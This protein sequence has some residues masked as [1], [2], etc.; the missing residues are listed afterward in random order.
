MIPN[1]EK[2]RIGQKDVEILFKAQNSSALFTKITFL[3][4]NCY[5]NEHATFPYWVLQNMHALETLY[6]EWSSFKKIFQDE[7]QK[8]EKTQ[9]RLKFLMLTRLSNL[10][11]ICEEGS[12]IDQ[13]LELLE[14]LRVFSCPSLINL[15]PS[16]V[17]FTHLTYLEISDC[18]G[19]KNLITSPTAQ[20][21]D[22]LETLKVRDCDSLEEI[23]TGE[24]KVHISLINLKELMLECLS[25]LHKFCS[26]N[27]FLKFPLLEV[28]I[29]RECP[30]M[31]I[32]SEENTSA[33]NLQK[34]TIA[35][36]GE[37]W[38][39]KGNLNDTINNMFEDKVRVIY[40]LVQQ[41]HDLCF[42]FL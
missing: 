14:S 23:I 42:C 27:C 24:E 41:Y 13:V 6:V 19:L 36:N 25:C 33:P 26:S 11:H 40:Q 34:V 37:D 1:V 16:S 20:S 2:L 35:E 5:K 22:K 7:A 10:Q 30:Q 28:V 18:N 8:S 17:T 38:F 3:G 15:L 21:L 12:Q 39:W 31:K 29:V 32:F 9:T 4:L